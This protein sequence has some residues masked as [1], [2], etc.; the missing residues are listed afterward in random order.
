MVNAILSLSKCQQFIFWICFC[1]LRFN[2]LLLWLV[3]VCII[4]LLTLTNTLS[5]KGQIYCT[6]CIICILHTNTVELWLTVL[7]LPTCCM[8]QK[9]RR[10]LVSVYIIYISL[11]F[12]FF[13]KYSIFDII[14]CDFLFDQFTGINIELLKKKKK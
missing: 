12:T 9:Q 11:N 3:R 8:H 5:R 2:Y 10:K 1:H 6:Q 13:F 7:T 14:L 4:W